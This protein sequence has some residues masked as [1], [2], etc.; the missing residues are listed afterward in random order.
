[1]IM[2][3]IWAYLCNMSSPY[4]RKGVID[5]VKISGVWRMKKKG[6]V[7]VPWRA[8]P[9]F[10]ITLEDDVHRRESPSPYRSQ[11]SVWVRACTFCKRSI[12]A[13]IKDDY[14]VGETKSRRSSSSSQRLIWL[15]YGVHSVVLWG[16]NN[17]D[18]VNI[19][20]NDRHSLK[21]SRVC[22]CDTSN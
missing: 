15:I 12:K 4:L 22:E 9:L 6:E 14:E 13:L 21:C 16:W 8:P 18:A 7:A 1:M 20:W 2:I 17:D 5:S 19:S 11:R 3:T 10:G